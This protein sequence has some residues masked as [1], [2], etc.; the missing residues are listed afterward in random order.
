MKASS[1]ALYDRPDW[2]DQLHRPGT[3]DE[4]WLLERIASAHGLGGKEWLEPACGTGR[5]LAILANRGYRVTGYDT[6]AKALAFA[7]KRLKKYDERSRLKNNSMTRF[8]EPGRFDLAFN[9]M[10]T[11]RHLLTERDALTHLRLT[12]RSLKPG[13]LYIVGLDLVA[14]ATVTDDE[15]TWE[16]RSIRHV[17]ISL[18][19]DARGRKERILNFVSKGKK[20]LESAYDLR[21]YDRRQW[22]QLI[23]KSPF[24]LAATYGP[25]GRRTV[26]NDTTREALFVLRSGAAPP[27]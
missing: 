21:S 20:V 26:L 8:C 2:Y 15:E 5:C 22:E 13:G 10:S 23:A 18:A 16:E 25:S 3:A 1:T 11:F 12:A 24:R 14:Y 27:A 19:P 17:M 6:N 4:I 7:A 9:M